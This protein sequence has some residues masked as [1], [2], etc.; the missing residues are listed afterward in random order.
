MKAYSSHRGWL[1]GSLLAVALYAFPFIALAEKIYRW[2]DERGVIHYSDQRM[3]AKNVQEIETS[4]QPCSED[5]RDAKARAERA[6]QEAEHLQIAR[7]HPPRSSPGDALGPLPPNVSSDYLRTLG[8]GFS[9]FLNEKRLL[10]QQWINVIATQDIPIGTYL[11]F[12][13]EDP[14]HYDQQFVVGKTVEVNDHGIKE[15]VFKVSSPGLEGIQCRNYEILVEVYSN[16][17]KTVLLG[18]H[19]QL[20]QSRVDAALVNSPS[21]LIDRLGA[22]G[23]CCP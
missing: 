14:V 22:R 21:D 10:S 9:Y 8:T 6:K 17:A 16:K 18:R 19:R 23:M 2:T 3:G 13:F 1:V 7:E 5:V 15:D 20:N 12:H 4:I 11:E